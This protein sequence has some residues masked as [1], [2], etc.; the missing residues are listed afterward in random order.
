MT[1]GSLVLRLTTVAILALIAVLL[2]SHAHSIAQE[3]QRP[4]RGTPPSERLV[5]AVIAVAYVGA[6]GVDVRLIIEQLQPLLVS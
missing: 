2:L 4:P 5:R 6:A 1:T 3:A